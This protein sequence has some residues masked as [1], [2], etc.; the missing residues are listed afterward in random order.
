MLANALD[1]SAPP[2]DPALPTGPDPSAVVEVIGAE[3]LWVGLDPDEVAR[4]LLDVA[5][6]LGEV[7][8][9]DRSGGLVQLTVR[10]PE[11]PTCWF[12]LST[13]ARPGGAVVVATLESIEA[14]PTPPAAPLLLELAHALAGRLGDAR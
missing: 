2:P 11:G 4:A 1:R 14:A 8:Y 6:E 13:H 10:P 7:S 3:A 12:T 5:E 9:V